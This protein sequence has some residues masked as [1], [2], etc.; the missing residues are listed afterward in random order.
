MRMLMLAIASS[1]A[2][3]LVGPPGTGKTELMSRVIH[4]LNVDPERFGFSRGDLDGEVVTPEEDWGF[5]DL[6]LGQTLRDGEISALE[7]ELLQAIAKDQWLL[8]DEMNRADMDRIFGGLLTWLSG[9]RVKVGNWSGRDSSPVYLDWDTG[10]AASH[11]D[12]SSSGARDYVAG[13]DWRLIGTYNGVDAQR[14]FR[15]GQALGRRFK[16]IPIAPASPAQFETIVSGYV[17]DDDLGQFVAKRVVAL[18]SAHFETE[19]AKL[20]PGLFLDIPAYV[21]AGVTAYGGAAESAPQSELIDE[22]LTEAYFSS[23]GSMLSRFDRLVLDNLRDA[24]LQQSALSAQSW[25]WIEQNIPTL[26]S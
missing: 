12:I 1:P 9:K 16:H 19:R 25:D 5:Q 24:L 13:K 22:L 10:N 26:R 6:V 21:Q 18:Y 11:V 3:V 2:V 8:L 14:V 4:T 23:V 15:M 17:S 20:G 7:G